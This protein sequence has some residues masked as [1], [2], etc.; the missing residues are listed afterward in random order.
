MWTRPACL[1]SAAPRGLPGRATGVRAWDF[2]KS[3]P[4]PAPNDELTELRRAVQTA[5][6]RR[7]PRPLFRPLVARQLDEMRGA[8]TDGARQI[9]RDGG[10]YAGAMVDWP[11]LLGR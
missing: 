6:K 5:G 4:R 10:D 1:R 3:P 8:L 9:E 7:S 2:K 11:S